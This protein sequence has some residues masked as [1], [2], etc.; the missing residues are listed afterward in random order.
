MLKW[1]GG[2]VLPQGAYVTLT[3]EVTISDHGTSLRIAA[4]SMGRIVRPAANGS[5]EVVLWGTGTSVFLGGLWR[6]SV[7]RMHL[8]PIHGQTALTAQRVG[9]VRQES[10]EDEIWLRRPPLPGQLRVANRQD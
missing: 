6:S 2:R 3:E 5:E 7:C 10:N 4:G 1:G 8:C 9:G